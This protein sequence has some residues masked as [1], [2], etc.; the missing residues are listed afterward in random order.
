[1]I[2][3][4]ILFSVINTCLFP[5]LCKVTPG[6]KEKLTQTTPAP[7]TPDQAELL[8]MIQRQASVIERL[9]S[10]VSEMTLV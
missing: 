5:F 4:V 10:R 6:A 8:E 1:M 2:L 7:G 3:L 9:E